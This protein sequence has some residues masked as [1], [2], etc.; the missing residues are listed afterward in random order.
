[1]RVRPWLDPRA[2]PSPNCSNRITSA[3]RSASAHAAAEPTTPAPTTA[4]LV[5]AARRRGSAG[6]RS[7]RA[8]PRP[9]RRRRT[10][11]RACSR[12]RGWRPAEGEACSA[13][14]ARRAQSSRRRNGNSSG[15]TMTGPIEI[16]KSRAFAPLSVRRDPVVHQREAADLSLGTDHRGDPQI[17]FDVRD[18]RGQ[19]NLVFGPVDRGGVREHEVAVAAEDPAPSAAAARARAARRRRART[20]RARAPRRRR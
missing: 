18:P 3:P 4:T 13:R 10:A 1:M 2:W 9:C 14:R 19:R 11:R 17:G 15:V 6:P 12:P 7:R 8:R 16:A 5:I 20:R